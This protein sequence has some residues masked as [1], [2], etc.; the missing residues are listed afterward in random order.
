M[1]NF[2][3]NK[4]KKL[5]NSL[6]YDNLID[7]VFEDKY[8][9]AQMIDLNQSQMM[10]KGIDSKGYTLG[11][12]SIVSVAKYGKTP[13]HITLHDTGEFYDSMKVEISGEQAVITADMEKP[14]KDL[15][16][17]YPKALGLDEESL[18][19]IRSMAKDII[20]TEARQAFA[21]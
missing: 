15:E 5:S 19:E 14:D 7:K 11:N 20:R 13:G 4:L 21:A 16:V 6:D 3:K 10:D 1:L 8:I 17:I 18:Q 9:Q 2:V 12:Y